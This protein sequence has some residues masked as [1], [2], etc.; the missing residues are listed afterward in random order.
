MNLDLLALDQ[1]ELMV[2]FHPQFLI[3][4]VLEVQLE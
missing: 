3:P 2:G 4:D 1:D